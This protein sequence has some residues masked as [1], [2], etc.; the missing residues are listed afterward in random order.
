[1]EHGLSFSLHVLTARLDRAAD[2]ILRAEHHVSYSRFLVLALVG[3]LDGSTQRV[4]ADY[5][6]VT[7]PSVSR[8][9]GVLA[10]EGL[11]DVR[12]D[13]AG[14][15]RRRLGLTERGAQL[16]A[17]GSRTL[18]DRLAM[19]VAESGVPYDRL[20]GYTTQLLE[21]FDRLEKEREVSA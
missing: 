11:L 6:G 14:G 8:M 5:L 13:P 2:R 1:M 15:N 20:L 3:E 12:P 17:A 9:T 16:V 7:E 4:L 19:V 21:T 10:G 18:E